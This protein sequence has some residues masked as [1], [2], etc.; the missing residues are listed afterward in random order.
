NVASGAGAESFNG[1]YSN[2][3]T[4]TQLGLTGVRH[5]VHG[6]VLHSRPVAL[7][8]GSL[9]VSVYYGA[10]D[11]FLHAVDGNKTGATAGHELWSFIAPEH[12]P[13]LTRLRNGTPRI[14]L[15]ETDSSGNTLTPPSGYAPRTYGMDG[16]IGV[17]A[18][19]SSATTVSR[20]IIYPT[21]RR[22]GRTVYA[23][24]VSSRTAPVFKWKIVGG[25]TTGFSRLAQTWSMPKPVV[26]Q[27]ATAQAPIIIMGGGYDPAEDTNG[28]S[29][30]GNRIYIING[31]TGMLIKELPTDYSV[32]SDVAIV[33][34]DGDGQPDR[35]YVA[36]VRGNLYRVDFPTSGSILDATSWLQTSAVKIA[37]VDGKVFFAP[38]VVVT[39]NFVAVL[40]GTGDRE[41]PLL[42]SSSDNFV[43]IKDQL[44]S[45]RA[46]PLTLSSLTRVAK[47]DNTSMKPT[48]TVSGASNAAGCYI[49]L[50][51]NGEKVVNAAFT[52]AGAS[53]FGTNR[54]KPAGSLSCSADL[55]EAYAYKFPLFCGVPQAPTP[56]I[57]GGL[58]P[59]AVGGIVTISVNG[60]DKQMPFLIGGT[61]PSTFDVSEPKPPISPARTRQ[62]WRIDNNR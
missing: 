39:R 29:D 55:G 41:K 32:P 22:G 58:P 21:M 3:G 50:A 20:A 48:Q 31:E 11:G 44:G 52:I 24:D 15:P 17:Y 35:A 36:D 25:T 18:L 34:V 6:D 43:L 13:L 40:V 59:S 30:I 12:I 8:Y 14:Q 56:I 2:A 61:G 19:Y 23:F 57:G 42:N 16:P 38:D 46:T 33:D 37:S 26:T 4:I 45:P 54:P 49:E 27:A 7:N 1:S 28:S 53:Y 10:N 51:T 62:S 9:G 47:I 60:V 5:S